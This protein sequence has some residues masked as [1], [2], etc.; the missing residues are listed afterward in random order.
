MISDF[1]YLSKK[2]LKREA[3]CG[4]ILFRDEYYS[5]LAFGAGQRPKGGNKHEQV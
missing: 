3:F 5:L 2:Y 4:I 1:R